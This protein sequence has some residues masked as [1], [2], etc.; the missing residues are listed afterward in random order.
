MQCGR[1]WLVHAPP[2]PPPLPQASKELAENLAAAEGEVKTLTKENKLAKKEMAATLE[3]L[4]LEKKLRK[5]YVTSRHV[6]ATSTAAVVLWFAQIH[7][8]SYF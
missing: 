8:A 3:T 2:P 7:Y 6:T 1:V 5:K 4:Q